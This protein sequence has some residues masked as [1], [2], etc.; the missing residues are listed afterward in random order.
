M[1]TLP[2]LPSWTIWINSAILGELRRCVPTWTTR[3]YLR[4]AS[5]IRRPSTTLWLAGF[6]TYTSLP[7]WQA[8]TVI[9]ACQ[10]SGVAIVTASI[11]LSSSSRRKSF[12]VRGAL[13]PAEGAEAIALPSIASST[14]QTATTSAPGS[15]PNI[16]RWSRP[17]LRRPITASRT[18]SLAAARPAAGK[19][20]SPA[21][22]PRN[23][24]R[25]SMVES[26][27]VSVTYKVLHE[28]I[29]AVGPAQGAR[30]IRSKRADA[31][32]GALQTADRSSTIGRI[33]PWSGL[34]QVRGDDAI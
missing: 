30:P 6:S 5:T 15:A 33:S 1:P 11:D 34:W 3:W 24:R 14:S 32:G 4:A 17:R 23:A 13:P 22:A 2:I 25:P 20:A 9:S 29:P 28:F 12:S 18:R 26:P 27:R 31:G 8:M 16:F 7:A 10:W 21:A 19:A